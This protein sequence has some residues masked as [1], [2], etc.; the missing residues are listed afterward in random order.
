[1]R[2]NIINTDFY[3]AKIFDDRSITTD[4]TKTRYKVNV[5][6]QY[7]ASLKKLASM[8]FCARYRPFKLT[9]GKTL[10]FVINLP[11]VENVTKLLDSMLT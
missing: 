4:K 2:V 5:F 1:M 6:T 7:I 9:Q 3:E 10:N 11:D 8:R